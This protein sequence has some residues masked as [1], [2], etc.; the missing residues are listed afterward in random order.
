M[1]EQCRVSNSLRGNPETAVAQS[2]PANVATVYVD[3]DACI[4]HMLDTHC[5]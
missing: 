1:L 5:A 2:L 4:H 3:S